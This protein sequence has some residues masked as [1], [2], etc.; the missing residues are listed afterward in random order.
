MRS[1]E[2]NFGGVSPLPKVMVQVHFFNLTTVPDD[3]TCVRVC[4]DCLRF[5]C[6]TVK[7]MTSFGA[8]C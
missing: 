5:F 2:R 4:P 6:E 8:I 7:T 1:Q 3:P